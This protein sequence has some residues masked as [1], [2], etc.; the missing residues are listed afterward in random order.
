[1]AWAI[2]T[3]TPLSTPDGMSIGSEGDPPKGWNVN[4]LCFL[5]VL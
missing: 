5:F 4:G 2:I 3:G 1:L